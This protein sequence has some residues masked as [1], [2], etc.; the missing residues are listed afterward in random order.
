MTLRSGPET[1]GF[2]SEMRPSHFP[3]D[4][5]IRFGVWD[6][7]KTETLIAQNISQDLGMLSYIWIILKQP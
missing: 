3:R 1:Y 4:L 7:T 2:Q 5:D 6:E